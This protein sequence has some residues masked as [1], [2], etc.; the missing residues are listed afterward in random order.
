MDDH[1]PSE[2]V[3]WVLALMMHSLVH[4]STDPQPGQSSCREVYSLEMCVADWKQ[5]GIISRQFPQQ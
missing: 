2:M 1:K 3:G 5:G 4:S